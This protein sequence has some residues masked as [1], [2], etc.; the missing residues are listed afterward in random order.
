[1]LSALQLGDAT[2]TAEGKPVR[3]GVALELHSSLIP[4]IIASRVIYAMFQR[5][6]HPLFFFSSLFGRLRAAMTA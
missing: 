2:R 1:M 3:A 4:Y 6:V 5:V